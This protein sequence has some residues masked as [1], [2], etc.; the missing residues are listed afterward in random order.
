[1]IRDI[2]IFDIAVDQI[3]P[4]PQ[5]PR[6]DLG[7][8]TE[9]CESIKAN[10]IMQNLTLVPLDDQYTRFRCVIGHRRLAAAKKVG[11]HS[12][13]A[14]IADGMDEKEQIAVM[15]AENM[16]RADLTIPEQAQAVQLM[17]DLGEDFGS[18]A[19]RTGLSES[20]V[21]RRAKLAAY[22]QGA[23]EKAYKRGASLFDLEKIEKIEDP[24]LQAK[25]LAAAGTKNFEYELSQA[26]YDQKRK[27]EFAKME[28][29][30]AKFATKTDKYNGIYIANMYNASS[31]ENYG[32]GSDAG[33]EAFKKKYPPDAV[34]TYAGDGPF[35][36]Y[37]TSKNGEN[38][39]K[40]KEIEQECVRERQRRI[41][42]KEKELH[43]RRMEFLAQTIADGDVVMTDALIDMILDKIEGT[44]GYWLDARL[45]DFEKLV[46]DMDAA[47]TLENPMARIAEILY[48]E[49]GTGLSWDFMNA[50][51]A[52]DEK[53]R[54]T[55]KLLESL[56]YVPKQDEIDFYEKKSD[57]FRKLKKDDLGEEY[58][59][60]E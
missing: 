29:I 7:D 34:F 39:R 32:L 55:A 42:A 26:L 51:E 24:E 46:E 49:N 50:D 54:K 35:Y 33:I 36:V 23:L 17:L 12:V 41:E 6:K 40:K 4:H 27:K 18:I 56:G 59:E 9:L 28:A 2:A 15:V 1:M 30:L 37:Y 20:T 52:I 60:D 25:C 8:L 48:M 45:K 21:R 10:G 53:H 3:E 11:L 5:N 44:K 43:H 38:E 57:C 58:D 13:P 19:D 22:D 14:T 47:Y 31:I 16:Q